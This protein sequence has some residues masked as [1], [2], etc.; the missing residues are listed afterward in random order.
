[1]IKLPETVVPQLPKLKFADLVSDRNIARHLPQQILDAIASEVV[2]GY[3]RDLSSRT[4]WSERNEKGMKL[5]LQMTEMKS[6]P[7]VNCSNVK[8]PLIT[9][10]ALQFLAR[11]SIMTKGG[12]VAK[13][14][15]VG[16]DPMGHRV[17]RAERISKHINYQLSEQD[18]NWPID[19][20]KAKFACSIV[21]CAFKKTY[22]EAVEGIDL[23][24]YVPAQNFVVDYWCK[25][26]Q[27]ASRATHLIRMTDNDLHERV[28]RGIFLKLKT[29]EPM[30]PTVGS[31][32][33][34][35]QLADEIA[36]I[37]KP[38]DEPNMPYE[39]LEQY[40]WIDLDGDGYAEPYTVT[41]RRD[42]KQTFRIVARFFDEGDV[43]RVN[44]TAVRLLEQQLQKVKDD[45]TKA[46]TDAAQP[47]KEGVPP[48]D[49]EGTVKRLL[50]QQSSLEKRISGLEGAADNHI[51][52]IIPERYFTKY[53]F[54][55]SPDGGFYDL[56][57]GALLGPSNEAVNT[58]LNQLIDS[59]TMQNLG[60]GFLG[61]GVKMKGGTQSF[62]PG[63]WKPVDST[64]ADLKNN[65][66]PL[67]T[68]QPSNVL[69]ELLSLLISYAEKISGAT[70]IM[71]GV[72]PGQNT[73]AETSRNTIE[74][75]MMLFSGIYNRMYRSL[76]YEIRIIY[77]LNRLYF[78]Q[79]PSFLALTS[80][81]GAIVAPD[82]YDD[83]G[84]TV[85]PAASPEAV[86][87]TQRRE[88]AKNTL[89]VAMSGPGMNVYL[90][91]KKYLEAWDEEDIEL[92]L[93][94]PQG[95]SA[96][97][98]PPNPKLLEVQLKQQQHADDMQLRIVELKQQ[99]ALNQAKMA[100][101]QAKAEKELADAKGVSTGHMIAMLDAQIG[102]AKAEQEGVLKSLELLQKAHAHQ[103][104]MEI[105]H[106]KIGVSH[107]SNTRGQDGVVSPHSNSGVFE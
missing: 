100:E 77:E 46:E 35:A 72:S 38:E 67:P 92:L 13:L 99:A 66:V 39:M 25:D 79:S 101:L 93:P 3:D 21:G 40:T 56:G 50:D 43:I 16:Q 73:P 64:G 33:G 97:P 55:P 52:R 85:L 44:D 86:S 78:K 63:E 48:L 90:A 69:F 65:I 51:I 68:P 95:K 34:L 103:G 30:S 8:F 18:I 83:T 7:W 5:A 42:T 29:S 27:K 23:S 36:G 2:L 4:E 6:F 45:I 87:T 104:Q 102:A 70:D 12:V 41:V 47:P 89:Q 14:K 106:K 1:M 84:F 28:R 20:E 31:V 88:K 91:K 107:G 105:E 60:G 80:G 74:Q 98:A 76:R 58:T 53:S 15:T 57:L 32:N 96:I 26:I 11:M 24:E 49:T 22:Y 81:D 54:I 94:D 82:D 9:V 17:L 61:R 59:G 75:G 62:A 10:A 19:D 37:R 71:T